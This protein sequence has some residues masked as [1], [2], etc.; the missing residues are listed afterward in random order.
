[1]ELEKA[2]L[3]FIG[4]NRGADTRVEQQAKAVLAKGNS[5]SG[6]ERAASIFEVQ[7]NPTD[8]RF[9]TE[10]GSKKEKFDFQ[11]RK[12]MQSR[13]SCVQESIPGIHM[14]VRLILDGFQRPRQAV[15]EETQ[16][17][18]AAARGSARNLKVSFHWNTFSFTGILED[19]SA[20]YSIFDGE[21]YPARSSLEITLGCSGK[22]Q[23]AELMDKEYVELFQGTVR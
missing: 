15:Q 9:A 7:F 23:L 12:K 1:M 5:G 20:E 14:S 22:G 18:L 21:G 19:I 13:Q 11:Q 10:R 16:G 17:L 6:Y 2:C 4:A 8:L 3:Q